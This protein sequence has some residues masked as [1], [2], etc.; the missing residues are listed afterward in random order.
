MHD[1][2]TDFKYWAK[3]YH[4]NVNHRLISDE[5][6]VPQNISRIVFQNTKI[7]NNIDNTIS[8]TPISKIDPLND[9][10]V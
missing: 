4:N 2:Q 10:E 6:K 1:Y 5:Q 9:I 7:N 8:I 3:I